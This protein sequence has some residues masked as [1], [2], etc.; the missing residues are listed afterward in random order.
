MIF[1]YLFESLR[2]IQWLKNLTVFAAIVFAGQFFNLDKIQPAVFTFLIFCAASSSMYLINDLAD[3]EADR[4]HYFKKKRPLPSRKVTKGAAVLS[5]LTLII[6]SVLA[7]LYLSYNLFLVVL[8]FFVVEISYTF[9]LK[10]IIVLDIL[11]IA[12]AFMLRLFAGSF[13]INTPLSSW[14]I[15]TTLMLALFLAVG[16]RRIEVA[17]QGHTEAVKHRLSLTF[18]PTFLLDGYTFMMAVGVIVTYSLFTFNEPEA[19]KKIAFKF[20]PS[21]LSSPKWLMITIPFVVYG[22]FRYLYL[23]YGKREGESP[24][25]TLIHD[26]PLLSTVLLWLTMVFFVVY[27]LG[28]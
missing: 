18:Y 23:I 24:E 6:V 28:K 20:L 13:V 21:T 3:L 12:S 14:L 1:I 19:A 22:I 8:A 9:F 11:A 5:S 17:S 10:K 15:L 25:K 16:K 2:P 7:S 4:T 26:L 27:I